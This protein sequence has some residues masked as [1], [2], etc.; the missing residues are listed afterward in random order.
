MT[1]SPHEFLHP[2][3][4]KPAAGYANGAVRVY[5]ATSEGRQLNR[6]VEIAVGTGN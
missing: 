1:Q 4:W 3:G 5:N 6:R 2:N